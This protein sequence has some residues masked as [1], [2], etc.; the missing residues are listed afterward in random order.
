MRK[1]RYGVFGFMILPF[2][3]FMH[4]SPVSTPICCISYVIVAVSSSSILFILFPI[5]LLLLAFAFISVSLRSMSP[6][7]SI[8][9]KYSAGMG[10]LESLSMILDFVILQFCLLFGLICLAF[11]KSRYKWEKIEEVRA[12]AEETSQQSV[13]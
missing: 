3:F 8:T 2:E 7:T 11:G 6:A 12:I 5:I 10:N 1:Q 13:V 4:I 9:L